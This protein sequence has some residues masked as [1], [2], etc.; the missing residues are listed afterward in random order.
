MICEICG[1]GGDVE[2]YETSSI[3]GSN[4]YES[5]AHPECL[6]A[7][8]IALSRSGKVPTIGSKVVMEFNRGRDGTL[9]V[10]IC[11]LN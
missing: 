5:I 1:N 9:Q 11:E 3:D 10:Q 8:S 6:E 2:R 4:E 7:L